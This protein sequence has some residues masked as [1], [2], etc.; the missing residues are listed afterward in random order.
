MKY[1]VI[2]LMG[3]QFRVEEGE[4]ILVNKVDEGA[5]VLPEVLLVRNDKGIKLGDPTVKG[6]KVALT[7][8]N[9]EKG[10]KIYVVKYKSKSRYRRRT[11]SRAHFTRFKVESIA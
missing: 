3:T 2:R 1:A 7:R 5:E 11:G 9:E 6:A 10:E 8:L 4:E